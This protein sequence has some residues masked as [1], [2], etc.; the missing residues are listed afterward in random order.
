MEEKKGREKGMTKRKN[1]LKIDK[2]RGCV[3]SPFA[4]II[5]LVLAAL[6]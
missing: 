4:V 6:S 2:G 3:A 5:P 1:K